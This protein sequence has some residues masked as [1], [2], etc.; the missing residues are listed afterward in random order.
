MNIPHYKAL[1]DWLSQNWHNP[2]ALQEARRLLHPFIAQQARDGTRSG[3]EPWRQFAWTVLAQRQAGGGAGATLHPS[4]LRWVSDPQ[5]AQEVVQAFAEQ[6]Y[7][8]LS[9][10]TELGAEVATVLAQF[11]GALDLSGLQ[12]LEPAAAQALEKHKGQI[13]L[14]GLQRLGGFISPLAQR[15][16]LRVPG[17]ASAQQPGLSLRG[18]ETLTPEDAHYLS[19]VQGE[20]NLSGLK[21]VTPALAVLL[22]RGAASKDLP[23]GWL[24]LDGWLN[25]NVET[26][27]ALASYIGP[28]SLALGD[29][30]GLHLSLAVL[31]KQQR[32]GLALPLLQKLTPAQCDLL[33]ALPV[34]EMHLNGI[35]ALDRPCAVILTKAKWGELHMNNVQTISPETAAAFL[36]QNEH[37]TTLFMDELQVEPKLLPT[38]RKHEHLDGTLGDRVWA[39]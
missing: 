28:L 21:S 8:N 18:L 4:A 37:G 3:L 16:V 33:A 17:Q 34:R 19:Y 29:D 7:L 13:W 26:L 39:D 14:D 11:S 9:G 27:Q 24:R 23:M 32:D 1:V 20:L 15:R 6:E 36:Q 38:L 30:A 35:L 10:L 5:D 31:S 2:S 12:T 25:P 22:A